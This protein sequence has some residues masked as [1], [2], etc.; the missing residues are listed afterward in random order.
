MSQE[1]HAPLKPGLYII[2]T[3][4]GNLEDITFRAVNTLKAAD[5]I[6]CEDTRTSTVLLKHY[7]IATRLASFHEYNEDSMAEKI[8]KWIDDGKAVAL[9]SDAGTPLISDPGFKLVRTCHERGVYVTSLPGPSAVTTALSLS[10]FPTDHFVFAGFFKDKH[11]ENVA[12]IPHTLIFF[13]SPRQLVHVLSTLGEHMPGREVAVVREISK[14]YEEVQRGSY[15]DIIA[16]F[17]QTPPRGEIV[18]VLSPPESDNTVD[19]DALDQMILSHNHTPVRELSQLLA[20]HFKQP[21]R[22]MYTRI[23]HVRAQTTD[24]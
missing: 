17:T 10:G 14:V 9:I 15:A 5:V 2:P 24:Q 13:V 23:L 12:T 1:K 20:Q 21:K 3:P 16:H 11:L 18:V 19:C 4:I 22:A 6:L 7:G 8:L